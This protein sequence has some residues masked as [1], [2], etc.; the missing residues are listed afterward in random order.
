MRPNI[1]SPACRQV[2]PK[3]LLIIRQREAISLS[4]FDRLLRIAFSVVL[5]AFFDDSVK[6]LFKFSNCCRVKLSISRVSCS[7]LALSRS[8]SELSEVPLFSINT[9]LEAEFFPAVRVFDG[10]VI[11]ARTVD[12]KSGLAQGGQN[13][14]PALDKPLLQLGGKIGVN[15]FFGLGAVI[16]VRRFAPTE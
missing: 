7:V 9:S 16:L 11:F 13:I 14:P 5:S 8:A 10:D 3:A 6:L 2:L 15:G 1:A 12:G 4:K